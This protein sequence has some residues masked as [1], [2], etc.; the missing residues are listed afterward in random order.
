MIILLLLL[1]VGTHAHA[2][3]VPWPQAPA[4]R[5]G[6]PRLTAVLA[7]I[8]RVHHV[9]ALAAAVVRGGKLVTAGVVGW[10]KL[11]DPTPATV[12]D[13]WH[14]GSDTKAMTATVAARLVERG[15]LRWDT[16]VGE[17]LPGVPAAWT[18]VT[19]DQLLAHRAGAPENIPW[20]LQP[21]RTAAVRAITA[22]PPSAPPGAAYHYSNAGYVLAAAMLERRTGRTWEQLIAEELWGPLGIAGAGFGGMGTPGAVDQPWGHQPGGVVLGNGPAAD[23]PAVMGPAGTVHLPLADWARFIADQLHGARGEPALLAADSYRHLHQPWPGGDYARGWIVVQREW[24]KGPALTHAGSNTMHYAV[25][26]MAPGIDLGIMVCC[27]QG[28]A[29]AACDSAVAALLPLFPP[30]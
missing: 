28:D 16:T 25:V 8:Q 1:L 11:G 19:L 10:R 4:P 9:P 29:D 2:A 27:N 17:A 20:R 26:W 14:L 12:A 21:D 22:T 5:D 13:Q 15:L 6:D 23:N 30:P 24:A 3:Q 7:D 18:A